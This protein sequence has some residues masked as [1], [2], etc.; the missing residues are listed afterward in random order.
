MKNI[1]NIIICLLS[2][3]SFAQ[4]IIGDPSKA[5]ANKD[6]VLMDFEKTNN[7]GLLLPAVNSTT[8]ITEKGTIILDA[9]TA[10][11]AQFKLKKSSDW[12]SYSRNNGNATSITANRPT[13]TD[14]S[15]SKVVI[16]AET[17]TADGALVFES[18]NKAVVLPTVA[19]VDNIINP[20]PGMMV[21]VNKESCTSYST[22]CVDQYLAFFNG[23]EW[24][25]WEFKS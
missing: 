2:F 6:F 24:S 8:N 3:N 17:S 21:F 25:F 12:F 13:T 19:T 18:T 22:P 11:S 20:S 5:T 23:T 4:I 10:T 9:T 1:F 16:G 15:N 7:R 14:F